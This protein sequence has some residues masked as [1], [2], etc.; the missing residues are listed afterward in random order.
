MTKQLND[1]RAYLIWSVAKIRELRG[2]HYFTEDPERWEVS[3]SDDEA[4]LA[5]ID[6]F[7]EGIGADIQ[8]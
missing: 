7:I 8:E 2:D 1:A 6:R 5:E 3:V 4:V